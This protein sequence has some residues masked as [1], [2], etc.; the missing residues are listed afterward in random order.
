MKALKSDSAKYSRF[1]MD[2]AGVGERQN[3]YICWYQRFH[4]RSNRHKILDSLSNKK[5]WTFNVNP[6]FSFDKSEGKIGSCGFQ[7]E[8]LKIH[9]AFLISGSTHVRSR[10]ALLD[11]HNIV[12][13]PGLVE[14]LDVG[15]VKADDG[16]E[17][18]TLN[19]VLYLVDFCHTLRLRRAEEE[20][21]RAILVLDRVL[22]AVL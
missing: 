14:E 17:V 15:S 16:H 2:I 20:V 3:N 22:E 7:S 13:F 6:R 18:P 12:R 5:A 19:E 1:D 10:K 8:R 21:D 4:T 11:L 9:P